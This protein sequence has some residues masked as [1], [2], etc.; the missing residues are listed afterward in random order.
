MLDVLA[1]AFADDPVVAHF[2]P[3][4]VSRRARRLRALFRMDL[5]RSEQG[6]GAWTVPGG[7]AVWLPP[8]HAQPTTAESLRQLPDV[9]RAFGSRVRDAARIQQVMQRLHPTEPHWYLLF[10]GARPEAQGRGVGTRLLAPVLDICDRE[11]IGAYLEASGRRN[12]RL[13]QRLGFVDHG[14]QRLP[15]DG[16]EIYP[17][18]R[19]PH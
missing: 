11:G 5:A 12:R 17:M 1:A 8:G 14:A 9:M 3:R 19:D 7:A 13:Y 10:V 6:G 4:D 15:P 2:I 16:P 18:W